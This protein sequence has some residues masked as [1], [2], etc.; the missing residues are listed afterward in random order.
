MQTDIECRVARE[1][2]ARRFSDEKQDRHDMVISF[3]KHGMTQDEIADESLFQLWVLSGFYD[4]NTTDTLLVSPDQTP[5]PPSSEQDYY[6][7]LAILTSTESF[8]QRSPPL[9]FLSPR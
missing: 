7:P 3:K 8:K 1:I 5:P 6:L 9:K 4:A 2:I